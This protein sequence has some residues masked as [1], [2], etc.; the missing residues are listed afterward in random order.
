MRPMCLSRQERGC[1]RM[2]KLKLTQQKLL[3]LCQLF[4]GFEYE[5]AAQK[6]LEMHVLMQKMYRLLKCIGIDPGGYV[7]A[8]DKYGTYSEGL[9]A[10]LRRMDFNENAVIEFYKKDPDEAGFYGN[11][12]EGALFSESERERVEMLSEKLGVLEHKN[13]LRRWME[14]L[15]TLADLSDSVMPSASREQIEERLQSIKREWEYRPEEITE[16]WKRLEE[17]GTLSRAC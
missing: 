5:P 13:N 15:S 17:S 8:L 1:L 12:R 3:L 11:W 10:N 14:L 9:Q 16:A 4:Y 2:T 6:N 7:F